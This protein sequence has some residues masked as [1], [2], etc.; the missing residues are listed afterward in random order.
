MFG[1]SGTMVRNTCN[2][3]S[4]SAM[5]RRYSACCRS[6][7]RSRTFAACRSFTCLASASRWPASGHTRYQ[8]AKPAINALIAARIAAWT[9]VARSESLLAMVAL[10]SHRPRRG[11]SGW[12]GRSA[13]RRDWAPS[14]R[15]ESRRP[16]GAACLKR[17]RLVQAIENEF[18]AD[19]LLLVVLEV[20]LQPHILKPAR[21]AQCGDESG[22]L[23]NRRRLSLHVDLVLLGRDR[24]QVKT[25][26]VVDGRGERS[27]QLHRAFAARFERLDGL[28][29]LLHFAELPAVAFVFRLDA[30]E[31][32]GFRLFHP[33]TVVEMVNLPVPVP[34]EEAD[35]HRQRPERDPEHLGLEHRQRH[36]RFELH[37]GFGARSRPLKQVDL[38]HAASK[39]LSAN[40]SAT[41][42]RGAM[43]AI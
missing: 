16:L 18:E 11:R 28:D 38:N 37:S 7:L 22:D 5:R 29:A 21:S 34:V 40:P 8:K 27:H 42:M 19:L 43:A 6:K 14:R 32:R 10:S 3:L 4:A 25:A 26:R 36:R 31:A 1:S 20:L 15:R 17:R 33:Q 30:L 9:G 13:R 39:L 35:H 41:V 24:K 2:C 23:V 12:N